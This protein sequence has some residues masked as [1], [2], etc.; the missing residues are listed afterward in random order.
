MSRYLLRVMSSGFLLLLPLVA[1]AGTGPDTLRVGCGGGETGAAAGNI[2]TR[3]GDLAE[4]TK[5]LQ[6]AASTTFLR[7]DLAVADSVFAALGRARF[8][9]LRFNKVG[10]MTCFLELTDGEGK[11]EV[12]WIKGQ[13]PA[14]LG[15]V[16][17]ELERAFGDTRRI[18]P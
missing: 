14:E 18:W 2:V 9:A 4:Y 10:N 3:E 1:A 5:P 17:E 7:K 16:L 6:S 13:P 12:S 11:H 15:P 8:R